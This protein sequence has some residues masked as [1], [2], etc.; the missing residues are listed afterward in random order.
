MKKLLMAACSFIFIAQFAFAQVSPITTYVPT[1]GDKLYIASIATTNTGALVDVT[2]KI[3]LTSVAPIGTGLKISG[4]AEGIYEGEVFNN[5]D[6]DWQT[7]PLPILINITSS[8][9]F[10]KFTSEQFIV[11]N[12]YSFPCIKVELTHPDE[13][14]KIRVDGG[15]FLVY[16]EEYW[17]TVTHFEKPYEESGPSRFPATV[18]V[19]HSGLF[20]GQGRT[21]VVSELIKIEK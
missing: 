12:K 7:E 10:T 21:I 4:Y 17:L 6:L 14:R 19:V 5:Q 1:T 11:D 16:K 3:T 8:A 13:P 2:Y 9:K 15:I 20:N 18:K